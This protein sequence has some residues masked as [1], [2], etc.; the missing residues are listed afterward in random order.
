MLLKFSTHMHSTVYY[1]TI[2]K[3]T[4]SLSYVGL[5]TFVKETQWTVVLYGIC[6]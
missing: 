3:H 4:Q 5:I 2:K 6:Q 1:S